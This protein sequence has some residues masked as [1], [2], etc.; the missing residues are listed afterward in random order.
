M[1]PYILSAVECELVFLAIHSAHLL[2]VYTKKYSRFHAVV[3]MFLKCATKIPFCLVLFIGVSRKKAPCEPVYVI[4]MLR[5][6]YS[7]AK[8]QMHTHTR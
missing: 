4:S 8:L 1:S 3:V 5:D 6:R 7:H 2:H